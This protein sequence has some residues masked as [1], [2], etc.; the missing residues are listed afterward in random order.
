MMAISVVA[1]VV[2]GDQNN[3]DLGDIVTSELANATL[4]LCETPLEPAA[5]DAFVSA[6][7]RFHE[8]EGSL[9]G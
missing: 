7:T 9:D 1:F 8:I 3:L 4:V 6:Q 5:I 2:H